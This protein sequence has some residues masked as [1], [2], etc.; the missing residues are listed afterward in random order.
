MASARSSST[1]SSMRTSADKH[2]DEE[3]DALAAE[4]PGGK[5]PDQVKCQID[6]WA[7]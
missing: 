1:S 7:L 3:I 5:L 6:R 4:Q 2:L